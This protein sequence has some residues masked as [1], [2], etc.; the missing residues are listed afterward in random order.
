MNI[1]PVFRTYFPTQ[2]Q[3]LMFEDKITPVL[4]ICVNNLFGLKITHDSLNQ[5]CSRFGNVQRVKS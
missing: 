5:I 2:I 3:Q 1:E 4:L